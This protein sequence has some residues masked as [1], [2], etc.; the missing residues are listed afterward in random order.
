MLQK[1]IGEERG[2]DGAPQNRY[3][4]VA[5]SGEKHASVRS[6]SV[7]AIFPASCT[8]NSPTIATPWTR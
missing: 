6:P 3:R 7:F 8:A 5:R 4:S 1:K 2:A